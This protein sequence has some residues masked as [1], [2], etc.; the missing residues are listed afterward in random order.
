M[1]AHGATDRCAAASQKGCAMNCDCSQQAVNEDGNCTRC[2]GVVFPDEDVDIES[3]ARVLKGH[4]LKLIE[5]A[6]DGLLKV[7]LKSDPM[8]PQDCRRLL[9]MS[10]QLS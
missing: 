7:W 4:Y 9:Q 2:A 10:G 5:D 8:P 3:Q 1:A 6:V